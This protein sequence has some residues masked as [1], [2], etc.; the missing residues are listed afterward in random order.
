MAAGSTCCLPRGRA[1]RAAARARAAARP[2][3]PKNAHARGPT[4]QTPPSRSHGR[5]L[6]PTTPDHT[7]TLRPFVRFARG[8][9]VTCTRNPPNECPSKSTVARP[10]ASSRATKLLVCAA[11]SPANARRRSDVWP[12]VEAAAPPASGRLQPKSAPSKSG[13]ITCTR[14]PRAKRLFGV[15]RKKLC[16][17][18]T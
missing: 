10:R 2:P 9:R 15:R 1:R 12:G 8:P 6:P 18:A 7:S 3:A 16:A 5:S 4:N 11:T 17:R 13:T 14:R